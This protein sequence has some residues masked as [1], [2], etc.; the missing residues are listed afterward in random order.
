MT[1]FKNVFVGKFIAYKV[2]MKST[3]ILRHFF[4]YVDLFA[5]KSLLD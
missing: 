1:Q 4:K 5:D 3:I 2:R